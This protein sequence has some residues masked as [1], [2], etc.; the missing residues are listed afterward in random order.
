MSV[1]HQKNPNDAIPARLDSQLTEKRRPRTTA[2]LFDAYNTA[3]R[4]LSGGYA[5][6]CG[7]SV[8]CCH[9]V[10]FA[11][12]FGIALNNC[13]IFVDRNGWLL[14][15]WETRKWNGGKSVGETSHI[16]RRFRRQLDSDSLDWPRSLRC[17]DE[18]HLIRRVLSEFL[19]IE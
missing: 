4:L 3:K 6:D 7:P 14:R 18:C 13:D 16:R 17:C 5:V 15:R 11:L 1:I 19:A 8:R 2:K 9:Q 10:V 12:F